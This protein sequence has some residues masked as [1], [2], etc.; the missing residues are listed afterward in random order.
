LSDA[1]RIF[2]EEIHTWWPL[3]K[4]SI[5]QDKAE[6]CVFEPRMG[7]QLYEEDA[8][9]R[10]H[11]WGTVREWDPPHR[12]VFTWHP[13]REAETAQEVEIHFRQSGTGTRVVLEHRDWE[14]LGEEA[15][16][17]RASYDSGWEEVLSRFQ[18]QGR[19]AS[20]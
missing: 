19:E 7:G 16:Q 3:A 10:K 18:S 13:G 9:G 11:V 6:H 4:Y 1:F 17:T 20:R 14:V 15:A 12:V 2:T 5:Q 8:E